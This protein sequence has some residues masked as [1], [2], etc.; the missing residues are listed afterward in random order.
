MLVMSVQVAPLSSEPYRMSPPASAPL[1]VALMVWAAV[2]VMKSVA[3]APVS[4]D[5]DR[6]LKVVVGAVMSYW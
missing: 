1:N 6:L 2:L 5:S 4:A 3:L